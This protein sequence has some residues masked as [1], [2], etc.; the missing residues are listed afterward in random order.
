MMPTGLFSQLA[1]IVLS[2]GIIFTY[3]QPTLD[4]IKNTQNTIGIYQTEREKVASV[5]AKLDRVASS[6]NSINADDQRRLLTYM[7][8]AVDTVAVPRDIKAIADKAGVILKQIKYLGPQEANTDAAYT[9]PSL[10]AAAPDT[11][12]DSEAH[13]FTV[14]FEGSYDQI[15]QVLGDCERNAYPLEVHGLTI[16]ETEGGFLTVSM[17]V[18]TYD[19]LM[20]VLVDPYNQVAI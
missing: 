4:S 19:R 8:D 11:S 17:K 13:Y 1:L 10:L 6:L 16:E 18:V 14:E 5:N 15:K 9:D 7:P 12:R 3:I 20:P 2:L